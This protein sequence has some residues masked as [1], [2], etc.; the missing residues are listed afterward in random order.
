MNPVSRED[1]VCSPAGAHRI[2]IER[3]DSIKRGCLTNENCKKAG[4]AR[5]PQLAYLSFPR[6][7]A[8][9]NGEVH[10]AQFPMVQKSLPCVR[11]GAAERGG[12]VVNDINLADK[13]SLR[14]YRASSLCTR[15]PFFL[16]HRKLRKPD[17]AVMPC[18]SARKAAIGEHMEAGTAR[19]LFTFCKLSL[20][21]TDPCFVMLLYLALTSF[22]FWTKHWL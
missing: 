19:F 1:R 18:L 9:Q 7:A 12:G 14:R 2:A 11:G 20:N 22:I 5:I 16:Y 8:R 10:F 6:P 3:N 15:E 21:E 4:C 17:L 13:Q